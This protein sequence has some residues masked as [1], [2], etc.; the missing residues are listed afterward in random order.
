LRR[1]ACRSEHSDALLEDG[2]ILIA[3]ITVKVADPRSVINQAFVD[4]TCFDDIP[5]PSI[6]N[7]ATIVRV[8][9]KLTR[10][11]IREQIIDRGVEFRDFPRRERPV[12]DEVASKIKEIVLQ[13]S[14]H[15]RMRT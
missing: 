7:G 11:L 3:N 14:R 12:Q 1:S 13:F 6:L 4:F 5:I 2:F 8:Y 10:I 9:V 15:F